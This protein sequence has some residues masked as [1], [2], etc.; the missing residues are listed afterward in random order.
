M[1][2]LLALGVEPLT[3]LD[4]VLWGLCVQNSFSAYINTDRD[5]CNNFC[6]A[7]CLCAAAAET[8]VHLKD[9]PPCF[10]T[11]EFS[12]LKP[13]KPVSRHTCVDS[14]EKIVFVCFFFF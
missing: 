6:K 10:H 2:L 12:P 9:S 3:I 13:K 11:L 8:S 1:Y 14:V 4:L 7:V 5:K